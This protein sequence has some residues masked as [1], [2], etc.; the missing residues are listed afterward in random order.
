MNNTNNYSVLFIDD[1]SENYL[2]P[3]EIAAYSFGYQI[4]AENSILEGLEFL[5][6][7]AGVID[8]VILDVKFPK[9][10]LQGTEG[11]EKIKLKYKYLPVI[12]LTDSDSSADLDIVVECMKKGAFNYVGKRTLN[13]VYLFHV[14]HS[15]VENNKSVRRTLTISDK[16]EKEEKHFT[17]KTKCNYSRF[18]ISAVF[19]YELISINKPANEQEADLMKSA[20]LEWHINLLKTLHNVYRDEV[21]I[22]LKYLAKEKKIKCYIIFTCYAVNESELNLLLQNI[23]HDLHPFFHSISNDKYSPYLFAEI[24][25]ESFLRSTNE[26]PSKYKYSVFYREPV[27][28]KPTKEFG[29]TQS[30]LLTQESDI[31]NTFYECIPISTEL[32]YDNE[33]FKALLNQNEFAEIDVQIIPKHL[34][35]QEI[36]FIRNTADNIYNIEINSPNLNEEVKKLYAE[37]LLNFITPPNERFLIS[38]LL[39]RTSSNWEAQ[40]RTAIKNYFFGPRIDVKFKLPKSEKLLRFSTSENNDNN[41][42]FCYSLDDAVQAFRLPVPA[43]NDLPGIEEKTHVFQHLPGNLASEGILM[44]EKKTM[45]GEL[46]IKI[47]KD[48]VARHVYIM[49]QTGTGKSTLMKTMIADCLE[50]NEG[51]TVI[52]P[53]GDLFDDVIKIIPKNKKNKLFVLNPTDQVNSLKFNPLSYNEDMPQAKSLVINEILR[54]FSSLYDMRLVGG[55]MFETYF[56]NGLLLVLDECVQEEFGK[57]TLNDFIKVFYNEEFRGKRIAKCCND[58]VKDFWKT[59]SGTTGELALKNISA[60]ITS[61]VNRFVDDYYLAPILTSKGKNINFRKLIDEGGILLVRIDKGLIGTDNSSLLGQILLSNIFLAGMSR[62]DINKETRKPHYIFIDE[63]QNFVKG[64]VG[65]ALSEVR[66]YGLNLI[67]ANQTLGQLLTDN[68]DK[69]N[70]YVLQSLVGNVGSLVFFRPGINDYEKIK[71]YLEPEFRREDVLKLPNFNCIARLMIDNV[72]SDPFVFQTK[73]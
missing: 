63:F 38:V 12:M 56:K 4:Y 18:N 55:P 36:D 53:H 30:S 27:K 39:K 10:E 61:K 57:G 64:D 72:P 69:S 16:I 44:G 45:L 46:E 5:N 42:P 62:T 35:K 2:L 66:K 17:I 9:G 37:Q 59:A 6:K 49:G 48:S 13:P 40:L 34:L 20:A 47:S 43:L 11:L 31:G 32:S 60:Y 54:A 26:S 51:F 73:N 24:K 8:A 52:D 7:Y 68:T 22:N 58:S 70:D 33:L 29:F 23:R 41:L 1:Q 19:G 25:E 67:L 14:I 28:V 50:K 3:L 65:T 21:H 71:H 15:A